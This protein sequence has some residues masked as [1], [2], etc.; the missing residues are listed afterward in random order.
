MRGFFAAL[1]MTNKKDEVW[2]FCGRKGQAV[3]AG[4]AC[5]GF[6]RQAQDR[7]FDCVA[8]DEAVSHSAQDDRVLVVRTKNR[9]RRNTEI[10]ATPE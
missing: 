7:L 4:R 2:K 9:Q 10:L 5:S 8:H 1:R 6:L 3:E